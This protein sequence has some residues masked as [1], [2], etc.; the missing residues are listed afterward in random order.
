MDM[1]G[2]PF[3]G[4]DSFFSCYSID[5]GRLPSFLFFQKIVACVYSHLLVP[6][7]IV[8]STFISLVTNTP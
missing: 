3:A 5:M 1:Q 2:E 4:L 7:L 8:P 6:Q